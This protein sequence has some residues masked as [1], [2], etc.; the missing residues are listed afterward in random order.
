MHIFNQSQ[1]GAVPEK[2]LRENHFRQFALDRCFLQFPVWFKMFPEVKSAAKL[3]TRQLIE[4]LNIF[5]K[6][7][8][9]AN[10]FILVLK[11]FVCEL[12]KLFQR[13]QTDLAQHEDEALSRR[14]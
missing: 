8:L 6:Q 4:L 5:A 10:P 2:S 7:T 9:Q 11:I 14:A 13:L 3:H 1:N 12:P